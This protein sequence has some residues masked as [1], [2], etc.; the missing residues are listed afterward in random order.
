MR[1]PPFS[2]RI[3]RGCSLVSEKVRRSIIHGY[4]PHWWTQQDIKDAQ[5]ACQWLKE[6]SVWV[7]ERQQPDEEGG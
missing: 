5:R 4:V 3:G 6:F 2:Q 7:R 1:R